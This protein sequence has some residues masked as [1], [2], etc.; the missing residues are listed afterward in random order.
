[1]RFFHSLRGKLTLTYTLVTVLALL[2]LE[3]LAI[4]LLMVLFTFS[5][6]NQIEYFADVIYLL[7]PSRQYLQ[8]GE[9]NLPELQAWLDE[10]YAAGYA[11]YE[12]QYFLD[13]PAARIVKDDPM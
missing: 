7:A 11:S 10:V 13:S 6:G 5:N 12:P 2:A 3:M 9:E 1:M 8:P 4:F